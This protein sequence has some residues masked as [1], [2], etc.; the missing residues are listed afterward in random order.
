[1]RARV[2]EEEKWPN[3]KFVVSRHCAAIAARLNGQEIEPDGHKT[4]L[5]C[6]KG[7]I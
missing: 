6:D 3:V 5:C 4:L 1:M 2:Q 7:D